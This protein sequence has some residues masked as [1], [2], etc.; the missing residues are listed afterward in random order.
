VRFLATRWLASGGR[1]PADAE[2]ARGEIVSE[3]GAAH[4]A[5]HMLYRSGA[6]WRQPMSPMKQLIL[7]LFLSAAACTAPVESEPPLPRVPVD[8]VAADA[9]LSR[10]CTTRASL[11]AA[12]ELYPTKPEWYPATG[13]I[14]PEPIVTLADGSSFYVCASDFH[15]DSNYWYYVAAYDGSNYVYAWVWSH[16]VQIDT[17]YAQSPEGPPSSLAGDCAAARPAT[18]ATEAT[19]YL[20]RPTYITGQ[21]WMSPPVGVVPQSVGVYI[22]AQND[23]EAGLTLTLE[24]Y[25]VVFYTSGRWMFA[26]MPAEDVIEG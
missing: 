19:V 3:N 5:H 8:D 16:T 14:F 15:A 25:D 12:T 11:L 13:W 4:M 6:N 2:A 26:W 10:A 23:A 18:A 21:G 7:A 22:C 24:G 1:R 17:P 20:H 9:T